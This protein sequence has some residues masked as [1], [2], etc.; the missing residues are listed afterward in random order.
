MLAELVKEHLYEG[1]VV[2]ILLLN[3]SLTAEIDRGK[4]CA[5]TAFNVGQRV[6]V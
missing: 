6:F 1:L 3:V 5:I 2:R 4:V